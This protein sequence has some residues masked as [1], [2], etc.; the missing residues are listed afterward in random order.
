MYTVTLVM[1]WI[2]VNYP[3]MAYILNLYLSKLLSFIFPSLKTIYI[4]IIVMYS[5]KVNFLLHAFIRNYTYFASI[6]PFLFANMK[7]R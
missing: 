2:F 7:C 4:A 1:L 5:N 3:L 6:V